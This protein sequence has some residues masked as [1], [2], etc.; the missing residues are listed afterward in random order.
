[1][2]NSKEQ[3]MLEDLV[4]LLRSLKEEVK[5]LRQDLKELKPK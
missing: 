5:G 3:E 2:M 1:M 4:L